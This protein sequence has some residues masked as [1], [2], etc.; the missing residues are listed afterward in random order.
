MTATTS[1]HRL[2]KLRKNVREHER[3]Y[4]EAR[5]RCLEWKASA[6]ND[7][8]DPRPLLPARLTTDFQRGRR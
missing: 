2:A 5:A 6:R 7:H 8:G 4:R 3:A 1:K